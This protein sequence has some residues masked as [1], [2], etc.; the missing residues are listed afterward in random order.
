MWF[1]INVNDAVE[2]KLTQQG[3]DF[4]QDHF[5]RAGCPMPS[6]WQPRIDGYTRLQL[7]EFMRVFGGPD[8]IFA[9]MGMNIQPIEEN[10]LR[11]VL[12][13]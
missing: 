1:G 12:N 8:G 2:F 11:V 4:L 10:T 3:W 6:E 9:H 13:K 5:E 7:W